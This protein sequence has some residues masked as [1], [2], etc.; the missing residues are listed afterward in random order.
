MHA[1]SHLASSATTSEVAQLYFFVNR[2]E[3]DKWMLRTCELRALV[4]A[5]SA[6]HHLALH[7]CYSWLAQL[8]AALRPLAV[9]ADRSTA[10]VSTAAANSNANSNRTITNSEFTPASAPLAHASSNTLVSVVGT[11]DKDTSA[12]DSSKLL[13]T[14][15]TEST[16][17]PVPV[18]A[19]QIRILKPHGPPE[20]SKPR[21]VVKVQY[22]RGR[23]S[24]DQKRSSSGCETNPS[25][26]SVAH[27]LVEAP[28]VL[29]H[30]AQDKQHS[31]TAGTPNLTLLC[32][33]MSTFL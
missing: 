28:P 19:K 33:F 14:S 23:A 20:A 24:L 5:T 21:T 10:A 17:T 18:P 25:T 2:A 26:S 16:A 11:G 12:G 15:S 22:N 4:S 30:H 6:S 27:A 7:S 9:A 32:V 29:Q 3:A 8:L 31:A 13:N 1:G